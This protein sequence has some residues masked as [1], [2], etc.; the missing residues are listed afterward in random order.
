MYNI[1]LKRLISPHKS[2]SVEL[3]DMKGGGWSD[4]CGCRDWNVFFSS[5]SKFCLFISRH[6]CMNPLNLNWSI[7][8]CMPEG[9][10]DKRSLLFDQMLT[11]CF[12]ISWLRPQCD[13]TWTMSRNTGGWT[14]RR[15][16][17]PAWFSL[18]WLSTSSSPPSESIGR[19]AATDR[20]HA[21][22]PPPH[23]CYNCKCETSSLSSS[24]CVLALRLHVWGKFLKGIK[25]KCLKSGVGKWWS[26][27]HIWPTGDFQ[28]ACQKI[29]KF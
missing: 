28:M 17:P 24:C 20:E 12:N 18:L 1:R 13:G 22:Y 27:G 19:T 15:T 23:V 11:V 14:L 21:Q 5:S 29:N 4:C 10:G 7:N 6:R 2:I 3:P 25:P 8:R 9:A 16:W 26:V